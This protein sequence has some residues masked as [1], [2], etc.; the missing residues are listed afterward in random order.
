MLIDIHTHASDC[1][2]ITCA[3]GTRYPS[4]AEH[5]AMLDARGIDQAV[6]LCT[7]SPEVRY[8][9]VTPYEV[10]DMA[11][12]QPDRIIPFCSVDPRMLTNSV[13]ADFRPML[14]YFQD[15]GCKGIGEY[16]PNL[17]LD[18]PLNMN[19]FA[20]VEEVGLPLTFHLASTKDHQGQYGCYDD[21]GLPRLEKVL[22]AFPRLKLLAHS[23]VF[24]SEI[25]ADVTLETRGGYP[26]GPVRPGRVVE[27]MR[28]YPNLH[29]D[30]SAGSGFNAISRDPAF[31]DAFLAEFADRLLFGTDIANV[32]QET[33]IVD[34]FHVLRKERRISPEDAE[35]IAWKN[36][37]RLLGL[38]R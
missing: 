16:I 21:L 11:A 34:Y 30:L 9:V 3:N 27:L 20:Q 23:Q 24:W 29:G 22:K 12:R 31:G 33:P 2:G 36:A 19:L 32:P 10:L 13:K 14:R 26:R 17:E 25:S 7:V 18:H 15:R 37:N 28:K 35:K 1:I 38:G 6:M 4:L 5:L 8:V